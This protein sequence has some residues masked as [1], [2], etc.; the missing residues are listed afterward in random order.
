MA[1]PKPTG[2]G[3]GHFIATTMSKLHV[4]LYRISGGRIG[5][6][7][8]NA[9]VMLLTTTGHKSGHQRTTPLL[10]LDLGNSTYA[11]VGSYGG[12]INFLHGRQ[13]CLKHPGRKFRSWQTSST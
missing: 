8:F 13:T 4:W 11:I 5:G 6:R 9:P 10:Y 1:P 2:S 3:I 12:P 7:M